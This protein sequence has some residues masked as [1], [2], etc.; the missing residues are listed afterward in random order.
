MLFTFQYMIHFDFEIVCLFS[1]FVLFSPLISAEH[2]KA[3]SELSLKTLTMLRV[4]TSCP[5]LTTHLRCQWLSMQEIFYC[6][7]MS[8]SLM[9]FLTHHSPSLW[10]GFTSLK[11]DKLPWFCLPGLC[12]W[13]TLLYLCG[14]ISQDCGCT[15]LYLCRVIPQDYDL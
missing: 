4:L 11:A 3:P 13:C 2:F 6:P 7:V 12:L 14:V 9:H 10:K 15:L 8:I 5:D 1:G